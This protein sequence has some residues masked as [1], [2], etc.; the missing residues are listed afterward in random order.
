MSF[1]FHGF[2]S[3][4]SQSQ[5]NVKKLKDILSQSG[6]DIFYDKDI[7]NAETNTAKI[8][9]GLTKSKNLI[10]FLDENGISETHQRRELNT[11]HDEF[12]IRKPSERKIFV[13]IFGNINDNLIPLELRSIDRVFC[14]KINVI[15][16]GLV[17]LCRLLQDGYIKSIL[18]LERPYTKDD[19]IHLRRNTIKY[20]NDNSEDFYELWK[21]NIPQNIDKFLKKVKDFNPKPIVL[22]AGTGPGHHSNYLNKNGCI[23]IGIDLAESMLKIANKN[24]RNKSEQT[25][26]KIDFTKLQHIPYVNKF[27]FDGIWASGTFIHINDEYIRTHL[28]NCKAYLKRGGV[29]A[30]SF[31]INFPSRI[32]EDGRFFE[33]YRLIEIER[34]IKSVGFSDI[35]IHR[36]LEYNI[37]KSKQKVK[38]WVCFIC[39]T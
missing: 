1:S 3:Y 31:Q 39:K 15:D 4:N 27:H 28:I 5:S 7:N 35:E 9:N 26:Y 19:F 17:K 32:N 33:V 20:Y 25:F 14:K 8:N 37:K 12:Y 10:L 29:L 13:F 38:E 30:V 24:V 18:E 2:L 16:N 21:D 23:V 11:F 34:I 22:D 6:L 36:D